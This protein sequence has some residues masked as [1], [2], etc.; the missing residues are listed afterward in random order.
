MDMRGLIA[1]LGDDH[2]PDGK[3]LCVPRMSKGGAHRLAEARGGNREQ[4]DVLQ[5]SVER[6]SKGVRLLRPE[7]VENASLQSVDVSEIATMARLIHHCDARQ[8]RQGRRR[9][10]EQRI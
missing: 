3:L 6:F 4:L 9:P 10:S 5:Q 2:S 1:G 8:R 7:V